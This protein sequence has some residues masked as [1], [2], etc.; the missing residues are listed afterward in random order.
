MANLG[1]NSSDSSSSSAPWITQQPFLYD[2]WNQARQEQ[3]RGPWEGDW[4]VNPNNMQLGQRD[5]IERNAN[6][7]NS[8]GNASMYRGRQM[9]GGLGSAFNYYNRQM[10]NP[11]ARYNMAASSPETQATVQALMRD[12]YRQLTEQTNTGVG[13]A[14]AATGNSGSSRR[15]MMDAINQRSFDDRTADV[16]NQV[17]QAQV[18]RSDQMA[19]NLM[20]AGQLGMGYM[21]NALDYKMMQPQ[22]M[23]QYGDY[24]QGLR[25]SER[26]Y[27]VQQRMAPLDYLGMYSNIV[28]AGNWGG[29]TSGGS[30]GFS[31]GF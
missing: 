30:D 3:R 20:D 5:N 31:L 29:K 27:K 18:A 16:T 22:M 15:A 21:G 19:G 10:Q 14:A 11:N 4:G 12:P 7:A 9:V 17:A 24:V 23:T 28:Q 26:D 25:Q 8:L 1:F 2:V 6:L 13:M